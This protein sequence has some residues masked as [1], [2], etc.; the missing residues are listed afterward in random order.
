MSTES[1]LEKRRQYY[2]KVTTL[3]KKS[4]LGQFLTPYPIAAFM[5]SLFPTAESNEISLL[6]P[7]A[8]IGS[9]SYAFIERMLKCKPKSSF[10][11]SAYE[12]D[13]KLRSELKKNLNVFTDVK[14]KLNIIKK[15]FIEDASFKAAWNI[16]S[17]FTHAILN[18]PYKKISSKSQHRFSLRSA[19]IETVNLYSAFLALSLALL[20]EKGY[21]VA[22]I[23]RSFCNGVYFK[24]FR[25]YILSRSS[26]YHL[27]IFDSR[28]SAFSDDS[29]L[30]EN[31][32]IALR[33]NNSKNKVKITYSKNSNLTEIDSKEFLYSDIVKENDSDLIIRIPSN[34]IINIQKLLNVKKLSELEINVS[35]GPVVDFRTREY[36]LEK[37]TP[38]S[39]PLIYPKHFN[40]Y[41]IRWPIYP[42]KKPNAIIN[43]NQTR[44]LF[45]PK[46][47]YVLVKRF[48]SKEE[49]K[50][51]VASIIKPEDFDVKYFAF[52]NHIN[53]Y[54]NSKKG[55]RKELAIGLLVYLNTTYIDNYFRQFSGHTQVNASDLR[56]LEYPDKD[57]LLKLGKWGILKK[58]MNQESIDTFFRKISK[59]NAK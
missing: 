52:E 40:N 11:I 1:I 35:T 49:K 51:I 55:L 54:H 16:S 3:E 46:G 32:I 24:P 43:N 25:E 41:Q 26:I 37:V 9:L 53:V 28:K 13:Q 57:T 8:G 59:S 29:V 47:Y 14:I 44:K 10:N 19:G 21:L 30:Q 7:G 12:I 17:N 42:S 20:E 15:D 33:K 31:I 6:D 2:S 38:N 58:N 27:H 4:E 50:R 22:I 34:Q 45:F 23:P 5:A 36:L 39:I 48:S 18:P 56:M